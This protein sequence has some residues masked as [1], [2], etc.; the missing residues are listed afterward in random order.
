MRHYGSCGR[1]AQGR[2][3]RRKIRHPPR[4]QSAGITGADTTSVESTRCVYTALTHRRL[5]GLKCTNGT[6]KSRI[7]RCNEIENGFYRI[8]G[9][10][11][12][13]YRCSERCGGHLPERNQQ[14]SKQGRHAAD[15]GKPTEFEVEIEVLVVVEVVV[16]MSVLVLV[17]VDTEV[18]V[19][20]DVVNNTSVLDSTVI[21]EIVSVDV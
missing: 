17:E 16:V 2:L 13:V 3:S 1:W 18:S 7:G 9:T 8:K 4:D 15:E 12:S 19:S 20:V 11:Q 5:I 6:Y 14:Y 21:S 10:S